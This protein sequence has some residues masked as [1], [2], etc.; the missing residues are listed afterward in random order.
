[1]KI[2][3]S[4]YTHI[5]GNIVSKDLFDK[6]QELLSGNYRPALTK[7]R[8]TFTFSGG[9]V[10]CGTCGCAMTSE[11][12]VKKSGKEYVYLKCSHYHKNCQQK[13]VN[14]TVLLEQ[15]EEDI[16]NKLK[17][18]DRLLAA[19]Q[20]EVRK[21]L[22]DEKKQEILLKEQT[23][24]RLNEIDVKRKRCLKLLIEETLT[25]EE[26]KQIVSDLVQEEMELKNMLTSQC[27]FEAE[28][29]DIVQC[30]F[31][32]A[33]NVGKYFKSSNIPEKQQI[34]RI[35]VSNCAIEGKKLRFSLHKPFDMM[36]ENPNCSIW[37]ARRDSNSRPIRYERTALT[38]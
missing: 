1:M 24:K 28:I 6:V 5:A 34:L 22:E 25:K 38:N 29:D 33:R 16:L 21:T 36:L 18:N 10:R 19:I 32:F 9:I 26:Y 2:K 3:D 8:D 13:N 4:Y 37:W 27:R 12:H 30:V 17:F 35:L 31:E 23:Q 7:R 14:E 11:R 15:L 20:K